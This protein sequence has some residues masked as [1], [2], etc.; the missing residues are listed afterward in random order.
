MSRLKTRTVNQNT[1]SFPLGN[2]K[3]KAIV[4][5][6]LFAIICSWSCLDKCIPAVILWVSIHFD[7]LQ[8]FPPPIVHIIPQSHHPSVQFSVTLLQNM[9][10]KAT[11]IM[12]TKYLLPFYPCYQMLIDRDEM[13]MMV[14]PGLFPSIWDPE[15]L[16]RNLRGADPRAQAS[17]TCLCICHN[18]RIIYAASW[19]QLFPMSTVAKRRGDSDSLKTDWMPLL[20]FIWGACHQCGLEMDVLLS[21]WWERPAE[22]CELGPGGRRHHPSLHL[23]FYHF[24]PFV[25]RFSDLAE[26]WT[27][28]P[29]SSSSLCLPNPP[30]HLPSPPSHL[31]T[32]LFPSPIPLSF[33]VSLARAKQRLSWPHA[34]RSIDPIV[35]SLHPDTKDIK[36]TDQRAGARARLINE[37]LGR[38]GGRMDGGR[39]T[40]G[41]RA[42]QVGWQTH[43]QRTNRWELL[44]S[45]DKRV[46]PVQDTQ[47]DPHWQAL[48]F[49]MLMSFMLL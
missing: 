7:N 21:P 27:S 23:L 28:W 46:Q 32:C 24:H 18:C 29:Q 44:L 39:R 3:T 41:G 4:A 11:L 34:S 20:V 9:I 43:N 22:L 1:Y 15:A 42:G 38:G 30:F 10:I 8:Y 2:I 49:P 33:S 26:H 25:C 19:M 36:L 47:P 13:E 31:H 48:L 6:L 35:Y 14:Y 16:L 45:S 37:A 5:L 40:G 12:I 17:S